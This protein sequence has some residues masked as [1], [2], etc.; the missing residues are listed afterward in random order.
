MYSTEMRK[1]EALRILQRY[2]DRVNSSLS[3]PAKDHRVST[4]LESSL[5]EMIAD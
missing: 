3:A 2:V 4:P 5:N 1:R